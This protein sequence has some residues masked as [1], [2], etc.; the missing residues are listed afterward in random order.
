MKPGDTVAV[1]TSYRGDISNL[2]KRQ[3]KRITPTGRI[4]LDDDRAFVEKFGEYREY[5]ESSYN[6]YVT[7]TQ[8]AAV[9]A[10]AKAVLQARRLRTKV[11]NY[12]WRNASDDLIAKVAALIEQE[13][14]ADVS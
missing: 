13:T 1:I 12:T 5:G 7:I 11:G 3:I 10:E 9:I 4:V 2:V 6:S 14:A 8:D